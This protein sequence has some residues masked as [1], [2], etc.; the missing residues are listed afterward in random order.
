M[1]LKSFCTAKET[2]T[3]LKR[4]PKEWEKI[5]LAIHLTRDQK[6]EFIGT[7]K[8][9]QHTKNKWANELNR[10]FSEEE[11]Q[12]ANKYTKKCSTPLA[13]QEMQIKNNTEIYLTPVRMAIISNTTNA[14]EDEGERKSYTLLVGI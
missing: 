13:I 11:V 2:V 9:Q 7:T 14:G 12:M 4:Q 6:P 1:K 8:N 10:Q 5:L 3:R